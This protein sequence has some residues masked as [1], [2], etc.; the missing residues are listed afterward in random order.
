MVQVDWLKSAK[1]DLLD[2]YDYIALDSKRYARLQV[3]KIQSA[4]EGIK[5]NVEIGRVVPELNDTSIREIFE[6]H[7]RIIYRIVAKDLVHIIY[8][9]HAARHFPRI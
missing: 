8:I 6:R 4:T 3:E 1:N 2:I 5:S 9:H 7:Y